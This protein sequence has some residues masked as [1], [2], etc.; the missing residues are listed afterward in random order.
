M[1]LSDVIHMDTDGAHR[2]PHIRPQLPSNMSDRVD[3]REVAR[4]KSNEVPKLGATH[5][6]Y[7]LVVVYCIAEFC[8]WGLGFESV[9]SPLGTDVVEPVVWLP[10]SGGTT[11]CDDMTG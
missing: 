5:L 7:A 3:D 10:Y 9:T 2:R 1:E 6:T 4:S 11:L 8:L